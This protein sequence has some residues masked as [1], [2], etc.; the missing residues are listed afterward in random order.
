MRV[1]TRGNITVLLADEGMLLINGGTYGKEV[2]LSPFDSADNWREI[3]EEDKPPD[4]PPPSPEDEEKAD[5]LA[6]INIYEG[7][8]Q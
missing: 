4:N 3:R 2:W 8:G 5:M 6:A 1:D 7:G